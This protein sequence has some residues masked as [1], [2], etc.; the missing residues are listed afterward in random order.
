MNSFSNLLD[1]YCRLDKQASPPITAKSANNAKTAEIDL[2]GII[3]GYTANFD[4][5]KRDL[6]NAKDAG[7][8]TIR[9]NTIGGTFADGLPIYN[10]IQQHPAHITVKIMGY[11]LSIGSLIMLA[12]DRVECAENGLIMIH[13][14]QGFT[15]GDAA[16]HTKNA[17]VLEKHEAA[18]IPIYM[19]KLGK[20]ESQVKQIMQAET[21]YTAA[22]AKAAGLID[23]ITGKIDLDKAKDDSGMADE[24][25]TIMNRYRNTQRYIHD[26]ATHQRENYS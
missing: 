20:T 18:V 14:A 11:A 13:R 2:Y 26:L 8:I 4:R 12:A 1:A 16:D 17:Q 9:L 24:G 6:D 21:W 25:K 10:W 19:R 15:Y 7:S 3:G 5:F 23:T 22:E